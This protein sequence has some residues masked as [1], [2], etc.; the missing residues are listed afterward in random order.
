MS[1]YSITQLSPW[2]RA[3]TCS[4]SAQYRVSQD[5]TIC[6]L[7]LASTTN[8]SQVKT[9]VRAALSWHG[10]CRFHTPLKPVAL[11]CVINYILEWPF[12]VINPRHTYAII[13][14]FDLYLVMSHPS[15]GWIILAEYERSLTLIYSSKQYLKGMNPPCA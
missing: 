11:C 7:K 2:H 8:C 3:L 9:P 10:L 1:A 5:S 15:D 14:P 13:M 4:G 6:P 12:M